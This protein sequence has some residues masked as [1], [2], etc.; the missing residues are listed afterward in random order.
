MHARFYAGRFTAQFAFLC[1]HT[2]Y[3]LNSHLLVEFFIFILS[4][5]I[6]QVL[7]S[8]QYC[9]RVGTPKITY[10]SLKLR[11]PDFDIFL[12][13]ALRVLDEIQAEI[14]TLKRKMDSKDPENED[15]S[16]TNAKCD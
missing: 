12:G 1:T 13:L 10:A 4:C 7:R 6:S 8:I 16:Y 9:A 14:T 15:P 3:E 2:K 5:Q 11:M